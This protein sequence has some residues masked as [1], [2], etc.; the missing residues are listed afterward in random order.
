MGT[1]ICGARWGRKM[2]TIKELEQEMKTLMD[3][4]IVRMKIRH[5][6]LMWWAVPRLIFA[7]VLGGIVAWINWKIKP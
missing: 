4:E 6:E 1:A 3:L 7:I 5:S 2:K